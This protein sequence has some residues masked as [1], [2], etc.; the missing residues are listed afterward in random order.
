MGR[1]GICCLWLGLLLCLLAW[2][3]LFAWSALPISPGQALAALLGTPGGMAD[4]V[5][6]QIRLPRVLLAGLVGAALAAA[7]CLMQALTRNPLAS[8]GL[9][10]VNAGAALGV[11]LVSAWLPLDSTIGLPMGAMAGGLLAWGLVMLLGSGWRG[12]RGRLVLAGIAVS[13]LCGALTRAGLLLAEEQ[14]SGVLSFLAGSFAAVQ[15]ATWQSSWP[16]LLLGLLLALGLAP[17]AN[18]L[19]LGEARAASLGVNLVALRLILS[20][21]VLLLV[22]I[23]VSRVGAVAFVGLLGPHLARALVGVDHRRLLPCAMLVGACLTLA[24]DLLGR[25]LAFPAETPAGALLALVGAP[26]FLYLVRRT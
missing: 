7:G 22:G 10:G 4:L 9:L 19:A 1:G 12:E 26:C 8:P 14:A 23:C 20:L 18:L 16:G 25:A 6:R 13:A 3:G 2:A 24:A 17:A 11:V 21:T 15:P 5:V